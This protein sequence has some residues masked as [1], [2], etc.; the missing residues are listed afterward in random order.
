MEDKQSTRQPLMSEWFIQKNQHVIGLYKL[1]AISVIYGFLSTV[2]FVL[3]CM[4]VC[5][6]AAISV[7]VV[8]VGKILN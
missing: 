2:V 8:C 3:Y 4:C 5:V 7:C 6:F 1:A